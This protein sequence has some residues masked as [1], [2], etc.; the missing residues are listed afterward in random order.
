VKV[1]RGQERIVIRDWTY[2]SI[3]LDHRMVDGADAAEFMKTFIS[4]IENPAM[5]VLEG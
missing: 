3:S 2:F 1:I 5:L 4:Y